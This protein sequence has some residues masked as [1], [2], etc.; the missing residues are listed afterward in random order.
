[1]RTLKLDCS[2]KP[3]QVIDTC[4][5]FFLIWQGK[6]ELVEIYEGEFLHSPSI[7]VAAPCVISTLNY[8]DS[9]IIVL[10]CTK[11]NIFRRDSFCCQYCGK[12]LD[13]QYLT[14]DHVLP[15]SKGGG[16]S[17]E[18][19]VTCCRVCNQLK[20]SKLLAHTNLKLIKQ[21]ERPQNVLRQLFKDIP[22]H[23]KWIPYLEAYGIK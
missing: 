7:T 22:K 12:H 11:N 17:W 14:I 1:M 9:S 15:K 5:A 20:G 13:K 8:V 3:I 21:P 18:N 4:E 6:A 16:S 19:L 10:N 2:F 23:P